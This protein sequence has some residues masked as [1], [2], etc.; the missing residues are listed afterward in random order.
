MFMMHT[1]LFLGF[2]ALVAG[3][4]LYIWGL[5][6]SGK[7][8]GLAK[9]FGFIITVLSLLGVICTSYYSIT[10]M[11]DGYMFHMNAMKAQ[12]EMMATGEQGAKKEAEHAK[13]ETHKAKKEE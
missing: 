7:G 12:G 2:L 9:L 13:K 5:R 4:A 8:T 3:L 11:R 6:T 10:I 1:T